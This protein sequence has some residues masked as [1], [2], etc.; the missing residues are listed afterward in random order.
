[1]TARPIL[2]LLAPMFCARPSAV[3][4]T[5]TRGINMKPDI[6]EQVTDRII[7]QLEQGV[8][9]WK[10][11]YFSKV[12]FPRNFSTGKA[13]QGINVFLLGSLRF[14]SPYFL[15]F[16]QA[17]ELGGNVRKGEHGSLVVK[18]G[19]YT[20]DDEQTVTA[21]EDAE[22]RRYLKAYTVFHASQIEGIEFPQPENL[23]ELSITEKT[24][25]AREIIA[26]MPNAP[27]IHE[28]SAVPCYRPA[29]DTIHMPE[30]CYFSSEEN[31]YSVLH[32]EAVH[33]TGH[34]SRLARK[35]LLENKGIDSAGDTARK[36][37]AEEELVAEMGASFLNAHAGIIEDEFSNSVAYL[38]SW[39]DALKS[40]DAKGWIVRAA[41]QAQKAANYILNIQPEEVK[42]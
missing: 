20:K 24:A 35:S 26:A 14:T 8:V 4:K 37:Y 19:T 2:R 5:L 38:Q 21:G 30:R 22:T 10:S 33:S 41:S 25:R 27:A 15:T 32:H 42:P 28:G 6:Y 36:I 12:G 40:K 18:Y 9:P 23:P 29:T 16:I 31:Y 1:M 39:I 13:Y 11:P 34:S 7:T 3:R 17:K